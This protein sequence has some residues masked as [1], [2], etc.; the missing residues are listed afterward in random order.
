MEE[1]RVQ[2]AVADLPESLRPRLHGHDS[3]RHEAG[4]RSRG[5]RRLAANRPD[6][7]ETRRTAGAKEATL[8]LKQ[9]L[10]KKPEPF[11]Y[12]PDARRPVPR[13][14]DAGPGLALEDLHRALERGRGARD[15]RHGRGMGRVQQDA[16][17]R[18]APLGRGLSE[19]LAAGRLGLGDVELPRP[20][21][22][23]GQRPRATCSTKT[24]RATSSTASSWTCSSAT[25]VG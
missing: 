1:G 7:P 21:R 24:S 14:A 9:E 3:R 11:R 22:H 4:A 20:V 5:R 18:R 16:A 2:E 8:A 15:R 25:E 23:P 19:Q 13:P 6:R 12:A 17:R 10:G